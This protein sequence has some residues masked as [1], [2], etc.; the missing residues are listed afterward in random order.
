[1]RAGF[2]FIRTIKTCEVPVLQP[3]TQRYDAIVSRKAKVAGSR[4]TATR[5]ATHWRC[6]IVRVP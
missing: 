1:V 4:S 6:A 5:P 3:G 2:S